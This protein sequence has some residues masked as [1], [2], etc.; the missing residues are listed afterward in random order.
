[1][2][3]DHAFEAEG[4]DGY[5]GEQ[6]KRGWLD[7]AVDE[8]GWILRLICCRGLALLGIFGEVFCFVMCAS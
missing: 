7:P 8:D 5:R 4:G 6:V 2:M 1:M 3:H